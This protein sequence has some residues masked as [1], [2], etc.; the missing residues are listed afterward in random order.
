MRL[1]VC[2]AIIAACTFAAG[3]ATTTRSSRAPCELEPS[4]SV[5]AR[6]RPLFRECSVDRPARFVKSSVVPM[7]RP[8]TM[9]SRCYTATLTFVVDSTGKPETATAQVRSNDFDFGQSWLAILGQWRYEPAIRN[10]IPVRQI[11]TS[12]QKAATVV[13]AVPAGSPPPSGRP[14]NTPPC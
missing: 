9:E 7:F 1:P 4:D 14:R 6:G 13:V 2:L 5:F 12:Q 8:S 10:G 11:V 3:C